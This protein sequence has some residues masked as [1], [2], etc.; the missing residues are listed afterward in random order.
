MAGRG[1]GR[2]GRGGGG[3]AGKRQII[4][5]I[6]MTWDYDPDMKIDTTPQ[7]LYPPI[8][9]PEPRQVN[10]SEFAQVAS[11]EAIKERCER[12][13]MHAV[14]GDNVRVGKD[15]RPRNADW[16]Y[17]MSYVAVAKKQARY[18]PRFNK[19]KYHMYVFPE[20]LL[21]ILDP[22]KTK[23]HARE[24]EIDHHDLTDEDDDNDDNESEPDFDD[25]EQAEAW[26]AKKAEA[27]TKK[28]E[29][30]ARKEKIK[31]RRERKAMRDVEVD[32]DEVRSGDDDD[33]DELE[34][35]PDGSENFEEDEEELFPDD[36]GEQYFDDGADEDNDMAGDYD[37][38][39]IDE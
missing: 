39:Q 15:K 37:E 11:F 12:G 17:N 4:G 1:R 18:L 38:G 24:V 14:L 31:E 23:T 2:G 32:D 34:A 8:P 26:R 29:A 22:K 9:V 33:D 7:P 28:A 19:R 16:W 5:G 20:E 30:T 25:E 27:A 35:E 13:P 6:E 36:N 21:H 3:T 10:H